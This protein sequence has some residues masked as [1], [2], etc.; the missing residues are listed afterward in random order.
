[1]LM[2]VLLICLGL[3]SNVVYSQ[4]SMTRDQLSK[5][6]HD[7]SE[8]QINNGLNDIVKKYSDAVV[9][10][11]TISNL[12]EDDGFIYNSS[13]K[14]RLKKHHYKHGVISG[15]L[16]SED[17]IVCTTN[18]GVMNS[19]KIVVSVKSE[20]KPI[21]Q[22]SKI[23][24]G[25]ND[26]KAKIIKIIPDL[27]LA[28][29]KITPVKDHK[30]DYLNL[31]NDTNLVNNS[32]IILNGSVVIGKAK[33]ENFV[34]LSHPANLRNN[35]S[36]IASG[37]EKLSYKKINGTPVLL[38][39]NTI[40]NTSVFPENEGGPIVDKEG[41]LLGIA[42]VNN[43]DFSIAS[44]MA[45]PVSVIKQ[46]IKIAVPHM[47]HPLNDAYIGITT[48]VS[49]FQFPESLKKTLNLFSDVSSVVNVE[50]VDLDSAAN[51]AGIRAKDII[52]KFNDD[53][54]KDVETYK[55]LEK[56]SWGEQTIVLKILRDGKLID[57]E[58]NR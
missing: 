22:D 30:F 44:S 42:F 19:D 2:K 51:K 37:I 7:I 58:I 56:A 28:F 5:T 54:V 27:N 20:L 48:T 8:E 4:K 57:V 1:M 23:T 32:N 45:I 21:S 55:N 35:F 14:K 25:E 43:K 52:L 29:L 18:T 47:I 46:A 24:L 26:Y 9:L 41:K 34:T 12:A 33:G 38:L 36:V 3:I 10:I 17:G 50:S 13:I 15:V 49:E 11:H 16:L 6:I 53:F 31:G 39:D 40:T